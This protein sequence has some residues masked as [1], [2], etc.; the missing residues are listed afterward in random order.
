MR[1]TNNLVVNG[2]CTNMVVCGA[3]ELGELLGGL[4]VWHFVDFRL[5]TG[6]RSH[7]TAY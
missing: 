2:D 5:Y 7:G 6:T 3:R 1:F 4:M